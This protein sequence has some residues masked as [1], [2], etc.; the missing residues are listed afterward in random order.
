MFFAAELRVLHYYVRVADSVLPPEHESR[1]HLPSLLERV[2]SEISASRR[3][4]ETDTD[5]GEL[6]T[7]DRIGTA[8]AAQILRCTQRRVQQRIRNGSLRAEIIGRSYFL[9]RKDIA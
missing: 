6:E 5:S 2:E 1:R 8:E 4:S 7:H 9:N 3:R